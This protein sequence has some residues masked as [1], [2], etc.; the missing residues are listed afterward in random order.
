[1][2]VDEYLCHRICIVSLRIVFIGYRTFHCFYRTNDLAT[3]VEFILCAQLIR[4][5]SWLVGAVL[6]TSFITEAFVLN[7]NA[8]RM[9][10]SIFRGKI[11]ISNRMMFGIA[12]KK[13]QS[14]VSR[15]SAPLSTQMK[16]DL[17]KADPKDVRVLVAG[18]TG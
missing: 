3:F 18:S 12:P 15:S 16:I 5:I 1:M 14:L 7:G 11:S 4:L 9:P 8:F 2:K 6:G 13:V 17:S 10:S